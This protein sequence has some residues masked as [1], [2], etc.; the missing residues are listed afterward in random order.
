MKQFEYDNTPIIETTGGKVKGYQYDGIDI[1]KGI[2]YAKA[3]RFQMPT[4]A[5]W[6]GVKDATSYGFVCPLMSKDTPSAELLVPHRYWPQDE[7]CQN[8]NIWTKN[9]DGEKKVP[10]M[11][12]LHGGGYFAGSSIEQVSYDGAAMCANGDVVVVSINHR[13]NILGYLDL[14][15]FGEKYQNS[16]NAGHADMVAALKWIHHNIHL[17]GGDPENVTI[18]GQSGGGMKVTDLMQIADAD[19]LFHKGIVMS[20]VSDK[21]VLPACTGNGKAIV[22]AILNELNIPVTQVEQLE[23]V[24]FE[25]LANAYSKVMPLIAR[26]GE[27]VGNAPLVNEYYKG[28]PLDVGFRENAKNIPLLIGSVFGEFSFLPATYDKNA[29]TK[30]Q[31]TEIIKAVYGNNTEHMMEVFKQVYP[32]KAVTDLLSV[33]RVFRPLSKRLAKLHAEEGSEHTYLYD[34]TVEFP[35]QYHKIAWHCSDIPFFFHNTDLI[36]ICQFENAK[37]IENQIFSSIMAFAKNADPNCDAI[38]TWNA[39]TPTSETTM[40]FDVESQ[41]K[42]NFDDI[43]YEAIDEI[44]P[45]FNLMEVLASAGEVQH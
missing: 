21:T 14:S 25:Q 2:P 29:I 13:L 37:K 38:P 3:E 12:W 15:P 42:E 20:G 6:D 34:F 32:D 1:F 43:L 27:Y 8:L 24:P 35:I 23:T 39:V 33:D 5:T 30:Q 45:P 11:V 10:V 40:I 28:N 16:G 26:S 36:E 17:F 31:E 4:D 22:T 19:G 7:N 41:A 18:F 44:L 9:I